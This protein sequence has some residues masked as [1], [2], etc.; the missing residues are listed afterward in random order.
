MCI[1]LGQTSCCKIG[2]S[3]CKFDGSC[4][5]N[6]IVQE[7]PPYPLAFRPHAVDS[8]TFLLRSQTQRYGHRM[9]LPSFMRSPHSRNPQSMTRPLASPRFATLSSDFLSDV[10]FPKPPTLQP[11]IPQLQKPSKM[12]SPSHPALT[13]SGRAFSSSGRVRNVS[14]D[15][16]NPC[17]MYWPDNEPLPEQGQIRPSGLVGISV[18]CITFITF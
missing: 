6:N 14:S 15:P 17:V 1:R 7:S 5:K 16:L 13:P 10:S 2:R 8:P 3:C 4:R 11:A 18:C 12:P 9:Q